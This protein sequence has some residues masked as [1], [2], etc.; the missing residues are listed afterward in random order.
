MYPDSLIFDMDGTLWD[1]VD[2]YAQS[3]TEA[4]KIK[5]INRIVSRQNLQ[6]LMGM[7]VKTLLENIIPEVP[8][9]EREIFYQDVL[10]QYEV[11]IPRIG[12][13]IYPGVIEGL[14]ELSSKYKLF[15]LSN[16]DKGGIELFLKYTDTSEYI[17]DYIEHGENLM[18][19]HHN[20]NLLKIRH[21]LQTPMYIGDTDSDRKQSDIAKIPFIFVNYGF[22]TTDKYAAEFESF[23]DLTYYF[24][25]I[26][27]E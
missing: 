11:V 1:A 27:K 13:K 23:F 12:A 26:D 4:F 15:I 19:K 9:E 16:C 14:Q 5:G 22:G 10:A 8:E 24:M 2:G 7:E 6:K 21:N 25:N 3:W 18:P 17:T 20:M